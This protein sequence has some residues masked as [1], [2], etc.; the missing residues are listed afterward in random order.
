MGA[1]FLRKELYPAHEQPTPTEQ[2]E[3][4]PYE[5]PLVRNSSDPSKEV[6]TRESESCPLPTVEFFSMVRRRK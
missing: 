5:F 3:G 6:F 1:T 2:S 4:G